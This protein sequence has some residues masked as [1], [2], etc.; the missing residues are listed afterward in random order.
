MKLSTQ[1]SLGFLIAISIDL[2]D[3]YFNY[4]LTLK[5]NTNLTFL[6]NSETIIRNSSQINKGMVDMQSAFRGFLLTNDEHFLVPFNSGINTIYKQ[7]NTE[8]V[9]TSAVP[10]Q[11]KKLNA[12]DSLHNLWIN[13]ANKLIEAKRKSSVNAAANK[14]Y[15]GLVKNQFRGQIGKNYNDQIAAIFLSF[16]EFEYKIREDRRMVLARSIK[17]TERSSLIFSFLLITVG[18]ILAVFIVRKISERI[19]TMVKLADSISKGNFTTVEDDKNDELSSLSKSLNEMS[20]KLYHNMRQLE[21]KNFEL[22]QFAYVVSHDLKAPVR[23]I[24]NVIQ[25]INEDLEHE[26]SSEMR[27]YLTIIPDRL[28]RLEGLIDGLLEYAR[29]GREQLPKERVDVEKLVTEI[30]EMIVPAG[31]KFIANNLP[32]LLTEKV[33]IEQVLSNLISNA[34][35][36]TS[37]EHGVI[38]VNG[39]KI[40]G[41]YEFSVSDNGQGIEKKYHQKIFE[42]FQT[43]REK[44][45]KE[46]TGIGLAIV[47]K[48]LDERHCNIWVSSTPGYG[49][50]FNFTWPE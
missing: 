41:L 46:S 37:A 13:Y 38:T 48:I 33:L 45:D 1:I 47:K 50:K 16:N 19:R 8:K 4:S 40:D 28:K 10:L 23:G 3:S 32:V 31:Y 43:L 21:K 5:V 25:W 11:L 26:I 42:I 6:S 35:K 36:H 18:S 2:L 15:Q 49:A 29:V 34:V 22:D 44:N 27:K 39:T 30:A 7:I 14:V 9:L 17:S 20:L 12:I 24:A